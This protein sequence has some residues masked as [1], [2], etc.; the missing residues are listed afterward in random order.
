MNR[1]FIVLVLLLDTKCINSS[2]FLSINNSYRYGDT[3][4]LKNP[5]MANLYY[6]LQIQVKHKEHVEKV[7]LITDAPYRYTHHKSPDEKL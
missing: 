1:L 6:V 2:R 7:L 4:D 3:E 5:F